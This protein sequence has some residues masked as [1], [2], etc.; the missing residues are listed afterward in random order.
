MR[1]Q[2]NRQ[3]KTPA[4]RMGKT[5]NLSFGHDSKLPWFLQVKSGRDP[6]TQTTVTGWY[7]QECC[8]K[9]VNESI[10]KTIV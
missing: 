9:V 4:G 1:I 2:R 6:I 5:N 3:Q 10:P 8:T 7:I